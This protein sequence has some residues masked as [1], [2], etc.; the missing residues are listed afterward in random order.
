MT[1]AHTTALPHVPVEYNYTD[2]AELLRKGEDYHTQG[3]SHGV[4]VFLRDG[5]A[6]FHTYSTYGRGADLLLGTYNYLDLTP[7]GRQED[8]EVPPGRSDGPF[9][10]WV[11]YHDRYV[12]GIRSFEPCCNS[13]EDCGQ[14]QGEFA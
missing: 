3:E 1:D 2:K 9:L 14:P 8:W 4:S 13:R 12:G 5:E 10:A 11:R 6:I 7:L